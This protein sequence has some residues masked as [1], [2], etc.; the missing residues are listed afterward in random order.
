MNNVKVKRIK[1]SSQNALNLVC[2]LTEHAVS[3]GIA[4]L[5]TPFLIERLGV[6]TYGLYPLVLQFAAIFGVIFG[7]INSTSSRYIAIEEERGN[8]KDASIYFSTAFFSNLALSLVLLAPMALAIIF[9]DSIFK[10]SATSEGDLKIFMLLSFASVAADALVSA[11][12][13][14]YYITNRLEIRSFQQLLGSLLK[15]A[16]LVAAFSLFPASL[17]GVGAAIF[18]STLGVSAFRIMISKRLSGGL[19]LSTS[20][21][22]K[23]AALRMLASGLWYSIGRGATL[24]MGGALLA[25]AN[26]FLSPQAAGGY[27]VAFSFTNALGGI[28]I[29]FG[30]ILVPTSAKSFARGERNRLRD[31]LIKDTKSVGCFAAAITAV[32]CVFCNDFF[33]IW[34]TEA[35]GSILTAMTIALLVPLPALACATP[36]SN[37]AMV[38]NKTR[39]IS[40][41][42]L[43]LGGLT[44][45]LALT[46]ANFTPFGAV[47]IAVVS[48]ISQLVWYSLGIPLFSARIFKTR[49]AAF[50]TPTLKVYLSTAISTLCCLL[51][52]SVSNIRGW[53]SLIIIC[54]TSLTVSLA[55]SFAIIFEPLKKQ[56]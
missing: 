6:E 2:G 26:I 9:S 33:K 22:S 43:G 53:I 28:M 55:V 44:L 14:V 17:A 25:V 41:L 18:I 36:A 11:F 15:A 29:A 39:K 20:N 21:V 5:L 54:A 34:V 27:S 3:A 52:G 56:G 24:L 8:F 47:G 49:P 32:A 51:I 16:S 37:V 1:A 35:S 45:A 48:S 7:I 23:N 46:V 40:L 19:R 13:S 30:A 42:F 50:L 31:S 4:L 12:D 10:V 38:M